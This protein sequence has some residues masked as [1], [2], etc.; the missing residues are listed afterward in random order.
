MFK[1]VLAIAVIGAAAL[2]SVAACASDYRGPG[3]GTTGTDTRRRPM[4]AV[5]VPAVRYMAPR[6]YPAY[7]WAP[8]P[9]R[10][11]PPYAYYRPRL[12]SAT[13]RLTGTAMDR[14]GW[15]DR[16]DRSRRSSRRPSR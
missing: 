5:R 4:R 12:P 10:W 13:P 14:N 1:R 3:A 7:R 6:Y 11:A 9:Y 15:S 8:A 2:T 16:D